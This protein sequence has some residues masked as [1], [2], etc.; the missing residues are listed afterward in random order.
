MK[1]E[2]YVVDTQKYEYDNSKYFNPKKYYLE[3]L[4]ID[5]K[6]DAEIYDNVRKL[7]MSMNLDKNNIGTK[8]WNPFR[9]F[10]KKNDKVIIKPNLVYHFNTLAN[11]E[12][13]SLITNFAIIRP[14]IDYTIKALKSTGEIIVG[15]APVQECDFSKVI[16]ING[17]EEA[18]KG[19]NEAGYKVRLIDFRKNNNLNLKCKVVSLGKDSSLVPLDSYCNKY[20]IPKYDLKEMHEHHKKGIHEYLVPEDILTANVIINLPKPKTHRKAGMTACLKNFI[21]I[22]SKKEYIPHHRIGSVSC[23]GDE[24]PEKNIIKEVKASVRKYSYKNSKVISLIVGGCSFLEKKLK[25]NK[26]IDGGW[27]GN[28]TL[29]RAILDINK[30]VLYADKDGNMSKRPKRIIFNLT[31]MI[32]SGEKE[33]PLAPSSKKVGFLIAGFNSL[34]IDSII[35]K[36]M[37]FKDC[38]IKYIINGYDL[39]KYKL[40]NSNVFDVVIIKDG[41][42]KKCKSNKI[43][44]NELNKKFIPSDGWIDYLLEEK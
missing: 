3:G 44:L 18:I 41:A 37:G 19:Y 13:D 7:F 6:S 23:N 25:I 1:N 16:N 11:E 40:S 9:D 8:D 22:S 28:D 34:N 35:C 21:G 20:A 32:I 38:K 2:V 26:Y 12:T 36:V 31:D 15:D 24:F 10:I 39:K 33:G 17:L 27:Y 43:N 30:L 29:W 4:D 42:T 14:I 5:I